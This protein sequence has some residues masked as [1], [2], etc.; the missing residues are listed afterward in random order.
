MFMHVGYKQKEDLVLV[1]KIINNIVQKELKII[2]PE[3]IMIQVLRRD[4][5]MEVHLLDSRIN[6]QEGLLNQKDIKVKLLIYMNSRKLRFHLIKIIKNK[7]LFL[8]IVDL[9]LVFF[10]LNL[11]RFYLRVQANME[12]IVILMRLMVF[13]KIKI[14]H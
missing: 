11:D 7:I 13:C 14:F 1:V 6:L 9:I 10:F 3:E 12:L 4:I 2:V 8:L 5:L